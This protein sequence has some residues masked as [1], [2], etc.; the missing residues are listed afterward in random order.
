MLLGTGGGGAVP[1]Q[2][3]LVQTLT[4]GQGVEDQRR[5]LVEDLGDHQRLVYALAGR[6]AGLR[7]TRDDDLVVVR[8]NQNL[9][10]MSG[11]PSHSLNA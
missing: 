9:V 3:A 6:L 4:G 10:F 1:L 2:T 7:V 5:G 11:L 8:L